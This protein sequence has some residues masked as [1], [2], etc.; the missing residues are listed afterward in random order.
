MLMMLLML[1]MRAEM[2]V[3]IG[4]WIIGAAAATATALLLLLLLMMVQCQTYH[5]HFFGVLELR[6]SVEFE[7]PQAEAG[8]TFGQKYAQVLLTTIRY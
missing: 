7:L 8:R 4:H 5:G 3:L 6:Q 1:V 2:V